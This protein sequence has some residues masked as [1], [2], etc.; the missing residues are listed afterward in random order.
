MPYILSFYTLSLVLRMKVVWGQEVESFQGL[1]Y[2]AFGA[3]LIVHLKF[4]FEYKFKF[5]L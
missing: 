3:Q 5:P 1:V 2:V 4:E